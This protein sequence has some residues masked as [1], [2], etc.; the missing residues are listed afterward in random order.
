MFQ[1]VLSY[2]QEKHYTKF[3]Y[4]KNKFQTKTR[5]RQTP[6]DVSKI[7]KKIITLFYISTKWRRDFTMTYTIEIVFTYQ[8][9]CEN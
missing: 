5:K 9:V 4:W 8:N 1:L 2:V 3:V 6:K 7:L